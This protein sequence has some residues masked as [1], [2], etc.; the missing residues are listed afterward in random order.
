MTT[1]RLCPQGTRT[2]SRETA[3][4]LQVEEVT[5]VPAPQPAP[6]RSCQ[7]NN[8]GVREPWEREASLC[9]NPTQRVRQREPIRHSH[10]RA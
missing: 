6:E 9:E 8:V 4:I 2:V 1:G 10:R 5:D 7:N 3:V